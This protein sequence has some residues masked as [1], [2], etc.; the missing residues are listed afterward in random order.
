MH[1]GPGRHQVV[2]RQVYDIRQHGDPHARNASTPTSSFRLSVEAIEVSGSPL[3]CL[4]KRT[5]LPDVFE[6]G[7][8][9]SSWAGV[10]L[11]NRSGAQVEVTAVDSAKLSQVSADSHSVT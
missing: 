6:D 10:W 9:V 11:R 3:E 8:P 1:L 5:S 4:Y 2:V 7:R